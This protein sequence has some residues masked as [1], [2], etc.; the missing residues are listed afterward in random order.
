MVAHITHPQPPDSKGANP[1][2]GQL[3]VAEIR[4][5]QPAAVLLDALGTDTLDV[6]DRMA[7]VGPMRSL[8]ARHAQ[9]REALLQHRERWGVQRN[10][11]RMTPHFAEVVPQFFRAACQLPQLGNQA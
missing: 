9:H 1:Q 7:V 6:S 8:P 11:T 3:A 2:G 10:H 5:R 4:Q